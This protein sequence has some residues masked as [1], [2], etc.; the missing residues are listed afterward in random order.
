MGESRHS[1]RTSPRTRLDLSPPHP[2]CPNVGQTHLS[3]CARFLHS[4]DTPTSPADSPGPRVLPVGPLCRPL[5]PP[6]HLEGPPQIDSVPTP[7]VTSPRYIRDPGR[8]FPSSI[9]TAP[10]GPGKTNTVPR[11]ELERPLLRY[12]P[13][14]TFLHCVPWTP[15]DSNMS[16]I[17]DS[18]SHVYV[19]RDFS[20]MS[21]L[22]PTGR[23]LPLDLLWS[24]CRGTPYQH[25]VGCVA[26]PYALVS[27]CHSDFTGNQGTQTSNPPS[28]P[29]FYGPVSSI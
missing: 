25:D 15:D 18:G 11:H 4:S 28:G 22:D 8:T 13:R 6:L 2:V 23:H 20:V 9:F 19:L 14:I 10:S 24:H 16:T 12:L 5:S 1:T 3:P 21:V 29:P 26:L 27:V 7:Y 17:Q